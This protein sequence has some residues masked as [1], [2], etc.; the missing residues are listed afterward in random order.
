MLFE[1]D[2]VYDEED[3]LQADEKHRQDERD[4]L[5]TLQRNIV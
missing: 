1:I 3:Q 4:L 2:I 5:A